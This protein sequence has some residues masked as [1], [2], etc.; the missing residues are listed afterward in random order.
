[1]SKINWKFTMDR[2]QSTTGIINFLIKL[3]RHFRRIYDFDIP[4]LEAAFAKYI[5]PIAPT[6][7]S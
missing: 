1:M 5:I 3:H 6:T 4:R 2:N 7:A